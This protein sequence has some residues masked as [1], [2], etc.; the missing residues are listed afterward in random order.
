MGFGDMTGAQAV[1]ELSVSYLGD[2]ERMKHAKKIGIESIERVDK[3]CWILSSWNSGKDTADEIV[4][5]IL[6]VL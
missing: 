5:K 4:K 2:S 6:N 1:K 3:I